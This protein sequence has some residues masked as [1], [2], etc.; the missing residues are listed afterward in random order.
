MIWWNLSVFGGTDFNKSPVFNIFRWNLFVLEA[1]IL[2][3]CN[4]QHALVKSLCLGLSQP[5]ARIDFPSPGIPPQSHISRTVSPLWTTPSC[6]LSLGSKA[7][8]PLFFPSF[9]LTFTS[10]SLGDPT[11]TLHLYH[12]FF[13][14]VL[15]ASCRS[16]TSLG[17]C[18]PK[19]AIPHRTLKHLLLIRAPS[20]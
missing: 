19:P 5:C 9:F 8:K 10:S 13:L 16:H 7:V 2:I 17:S 12:P 6:I 18:I 20:L 14:G 3:K 11:S 4:F 15:P 1:Q